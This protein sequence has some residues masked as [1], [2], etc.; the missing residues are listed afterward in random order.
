MD[1]ERDRRA[2]EREQERLGSLD[3]LLRRLEAFA[4]ERAELTRAEESYLRSE[5]RHKA[6]RG[7]Y[8]HLYDAFFRE[9]AG[10]IAQGLEEGNPCPVC[11]STS[12]P[13]KARISNEAPS[14]ADLTLAK[15]RADAARAELEQASAQISA[16][17]AAAQAREDSLRVGIRSLLGDCPLDDAQGRC[18]DERGA[19]ERKI[20]ALE[21]EVAAGEERAKRGTMLNEQAGAAE[22]ALADYRRRGQTLATN[23]ASLEA[24]LAELQRQQFDLPYPNEACANAERERMQREVRGIDKALDE[25]RKERESAQR[26]CN[27]LEG[28]VRQSED[29]L[30]DVADLSNVDGELDAVGK[31]LLQVESDL[32]RL[33]AQIGT[34]EARKERREQAA[35]EMLAQDAR[36]KE[37]VAKK[38]EL[39]Q[40]IS[41]LGADA[42]GLSAQ[43]KTLMGRLLYPSEDQAIARLNE[44]EEMV[45]LHDERLQKAEAELDEWQATIN[46]VNGELSQAREQLSDGADVNDVEGSLRAAQ[47]E[48]EERSREQEDLRQRIAQ[49]ERDVRRAGELAELVAQLNKELQRMQ[50]SRQ[51]LETDLASQRASLLATANQVADKAERLDFASKEEAQTHL[52]ELRCQLEMMQESYERAVS[53]SRDVSSKMEN[54]DGQI[55][56]LKRR[57]EELG[58]LNKEALAKERGDLERRRQAL[59][60][61]RDVLYARLASNKSTREKI[62]ASLVR[63]QESE[64]AYV[65]VGSL[66]KT[67]NG[68]LYGKDRI[69][70]EAYV[71]RTYFER[72]LQRA[73]LRL[74]D[75][76]GGQYEFRRQEGSGDLRAKSGLELEVVD[77]YNGS[78][79]SVRTLS[80]GESFMAALS[81]ALGLADEIQS[82]AGGIRIETMFIDEGFGSL[83]ENALQQAIDALQGVTAE[84]KLVGIISHV[85]ELKE[86][87]DRQVVVTKNKTGGSSVEVVC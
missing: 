41:Q 29:Q 69:T 14:E 83:D 21:R 79:R 19:S 47:A 59:T 11:G 6:L 52:E 66:S 65:M 53:H 12:H 3:D 17:K 27:E 44:L 54:L 46:R 86:R 75:M 20:E 51:E 67:A 26:R 64:D 50:T 22:L 72:M 87:I 71:Q 78:T 56:E 15:E 68:D 1:V 84:T 43:V 7:A 9:Q 81:L 36:Q 82:N 39:E 45:R 73:N 34:E 24:R 16:K 23:I 8:E 62:L 5:Q 77:H 37:L 70:L 18:V 74:L 40:G 32:Q 49:A 13:H 2:L 76:T 35:R 80:G 60:E 63:V 85:S 30:K 28:R 33:V 38:G 25:C 55:R 42:H 4:N 58:D 31:G 61:R 57:I 48:L 10:I